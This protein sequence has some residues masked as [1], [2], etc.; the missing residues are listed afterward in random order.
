MKKKGFTL[1]ELLVVIA[2]IAML[3]AILM[4]ALNK[5]KQLAQR[6]ICA[7]NLRGMGTALAV[8]S[9]DDKYEQ[10]PNLTLRGGVVHDW[11][12]STTN[13]SN[14]S[15]YPKDWT[16]QGDLTV[17]AHL[18]MLVREADV[19]PKSF[20]C[21]G[22][23]QRPF[24]NVPDNLELVELWDFGS[25]TYPTTQAPTGANVCVSYAYQN[26]FEVNAA[27][28]A[29]PANPT[30]S[31]SMALMA[32]RNPYWEDPAVADR[33][34]AITDTNYMG[35]ADLLNPADIPDTVLK[36]RVQGA[37]SFAHNR[38]GQNV[39]FND[40]H[41][42][43]HRRPDVGVG[44]DNIYTCYSGGA[45]P[46]W[47]QDQRRQGGPRNPSNSSGAIRDKRDSYLVNDPQY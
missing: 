21:K 33:T 29:F 13:W 31:S 38:E 44:N 47:T 6:L 17:S 8:Y 30:A 3:L 42:L 7:T 37:N 46:P 40:G 34:I 18:F 39:L 11:E 36:W 26:P 2:I 1:I 5:V 10:Y 45:T 14:T 23:D 16:T 19:D 41:T 32:D 20:V 24:D 4:P 25:P 22:S 43:F 15:P 12:S 9:N 28:P 35:V 27:L